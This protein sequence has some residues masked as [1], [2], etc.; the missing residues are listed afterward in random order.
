MLRTGLGEAVRGALNVP[1]L[2]NGLPHRNDEPRSKDV[3]APHR[4]Q[5]LPDASENAVD[6]QQGTDAPPPVKMDLGFPT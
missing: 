4:L 3:N 6:E 1:L 5:A 2:N